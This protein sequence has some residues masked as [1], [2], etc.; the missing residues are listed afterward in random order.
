MR[1]HSRRA[2]L[3]SS[4][5]VMTSLLGLA[6]TSSATSN[7]NCHVITTAGGG[8]NTGADWSNPCAGF[9]G[10][11]AGGAMVHGDTYYVAGG[12][13]ANYSSSSTTSPLLNVTSTGANTSLPVVIKAATVAD[14][15]TSTGWNPSTMAVDG[16]AGQAIFTAAYVT[17]FQFSTPNVTLDGNHG[18][19]DTS[20]SWGNPLHACA[21]T[22]CGIKVDFSTP[23]AF[24]STH[25]MWPF[26]ALT[27]A[28][29]LTIRATEFVG[30]YTTCGSQG[31]LSDTFHADITV[32]TPANTLITHNYWHDASQGYVATH[33]TTGT[34]VTYNYFLRNYS[35]AT[36]PA[37]HGYTWSI[38]G[39]SNLTFAFNAVQDQQ[40]TAVIDEVNSVCCNATTNLRFY[41]NVIW[42]SSGNPNTGGFGNGIVSCTNGD[43]CTGWLVYN[44]TI[45]NGTINLSNSL[46]FGN[47]T[48]G[49][50]SSITEAN[51]LFWNATPANNGNLCGTAATCSAD[52]DYFSGTTHTAQGHEQ[53]TSVNP[54]V[55]W[56]GSNFRLTA[57][58]NAGVALSA[59]FNVDPDGNARTTWTRGA[60]QFGAT[61]SS[62]V[63]PT[64]LTA[65]VE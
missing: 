22:Q 62:V 41:G 65:T 7:G 57:D 30:C 52:Y 47:G 16:G 5:L 38:Q 1:S 12:S 34:T 54:F 45:A 35:S 10:N 19:S 3:L 15:C 27:G 29:N 64:Q 31:L 49:S 53:V 17:T 50:G 59:P 4:T 61:A 56:T 46:S 24:Q 9:T 37:V 60:F 58:T 11:C 21:G 18:A 26:Y 13:G 43:T 55:N 32:P 25:F 14:H 28:D 44:N 51:N 48:P 42:T 23:S 33:G 6:A 36:S 39:G 2:F 40:G 8:T 63:P 20:S